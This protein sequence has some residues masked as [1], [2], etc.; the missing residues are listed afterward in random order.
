MQMWPKAGTNEPDQTRGKRGKSHIDSIYRQRAKAPYT[1]KLMARFEPG[2]LPDNP[3][4]TTMKENY[5]IAARSSPPAIPNPV[6][7]ERSVEDISN[8]HITQDPDLARPKNVAKSVESSMD[9]ADYWVSY[10]EN[11]YVR[12][13]WK[14]VRHAQ[15][16]SRFKVS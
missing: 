1:G 15:I 9:Q 3:K 6:S 4:T 12:L 2:S 7:K 11:G 14:C 5:L 16:V 13:K 8:E 10:L